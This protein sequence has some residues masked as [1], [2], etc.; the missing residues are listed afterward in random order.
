MLKRLGLVPAV[1]T[2]IGCASSSNEI[3]S[4]YVSP[5]EYEN[6]TCKQLAREGQRVAERAAMLAGRIDDNARDDKIVAGVGAVL[7]WPA[8]LFIDG[9]GPEAT[10]YAQLKGQRKAI[11]EESFRRDCNVEFRDEEG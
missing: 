10:E 6:Y 5:L 2:L 4:A 9:D 1:A 7:F 11:E 8:L 3:S